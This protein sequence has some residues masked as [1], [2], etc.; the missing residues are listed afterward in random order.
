M[1]APVFQGRREVVVTLP[2]P[3]GGRPEVTLAQLLEP[4]P[5]IWQHQK[6]HFSL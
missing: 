4:F 2:E 1:A 5:I 3:G 6:L